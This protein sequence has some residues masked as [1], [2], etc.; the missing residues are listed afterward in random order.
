M[1]C[2]W[3]LWNVQYLPF[4]LLSRLVFIPYGH[5][6]D[7]LSFIRIRTCFIGMV[8]GVKLKNRLLGLFFFDVGWSST[9]WAV[10]FLDEGMLEDLPPSMFAYFMNEGRPFQPF[11]FLWPT[12]PVYPWHSCTFK[13]YI[14]ILPWY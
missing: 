13:P 12:V 7:W 11:I 14:E 10:Y 3:S 2:P 9:F 4:D 8:K 1:M 6:N 5:Y